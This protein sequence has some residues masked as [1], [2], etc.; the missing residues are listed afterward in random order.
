MKYL[1]YISFLLIFFYLN[2]V[3]MASNN[4]VKFEQF[5]SG[6]CQLNNS[7]V[8]RISQKLAPYFETILDS[9]MDDFL[10]LTQEVRLTP[11]TRRSH[12]K[13][14]EN[15]ARITAAETHR[16]IFENESL[17]ILESRVKPGQVVPFHTHQWDSLILTLQ[18]SEF[19]VNDGGDVKTEN[20]MPTAEKSEGS[21]C[22][23]SYRN[24]GNAE[25]RAL[26]FE[27][28]K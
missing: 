23:Y 16:L 7:D 1:R 13:M 22:L 3:I 20:W 4:V 5:L 6:T 10:L 17:R 11:I 15:D 2:Q 14:S 19:Q 9:Q 21:S 8:I 27:F 12:S 28:K 25:F 18:G 24:I 26:I